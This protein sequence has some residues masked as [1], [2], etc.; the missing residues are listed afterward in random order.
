[1]TLSLI[2]KKILKKIS[3]SSH[4]CSCRMQRTKSTSSPSSSSTACIDRMR[5]SVVIL[6]FWQKESMVDNGISRRERLYAITWSPSTDDIAD[7][8]NAARQYVA[9]L[10]DP[11]E[12]HKDAHGDLNAIRVQFADTVVPLH[13]LPPS[14]PSFLQH[15]KWAFFQTRIWMLSHIAMPDM[16]SPDGHGWQR[17]GNDMKLRLFDGPS[18]AEMLVEL[19]CS[20]HGWQPCSGNCSCARNAMTW[21]E[22]CLCKATEGCRNENTHRGRIDDKVE[23]DQ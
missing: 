12:L 8:V 23:G 4:S 1:M 16:P 3:W 5:H 21:T 7:A 19:L 22:E 10:Y 9:A 20:C 11:K 2:S 6:Q 15:V 13:K 14:E 18:A 17:K